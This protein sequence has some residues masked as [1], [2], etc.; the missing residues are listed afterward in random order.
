[1]FDTFRSFAF[2][3]RFPFDD[4]VDEA[5][6]FFDPLASDDV[7]ETNRGLLDPLELLRVRTEDA[8]SGDLDL[9]EARDFSDPDR[10]GDLDRS[11]P[12]LFFSLF[13]AISVSELSPEEDEDEL[14]D[15]DLEDILS[16]PDFC[17]TK[18][19]N[20]EHSSI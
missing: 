13:P 8:F 9:D 3:F 7:A 17:S 11:D 4:V 1:M 20:V 6:D 16:N 2:N 10:E 18:V 19:F 15:E 12:E 5:S 14:A